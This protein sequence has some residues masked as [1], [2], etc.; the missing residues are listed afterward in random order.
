[1]DNASGAASV[2]CLIAFSTGGRALV[3]INSSPGC[4]EMPIDRKALKAAWVVGPADGAVINSRIKLR[5]VF[6]ASVTS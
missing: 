2:C 6:I 5:I 1:M 4:K 3:T